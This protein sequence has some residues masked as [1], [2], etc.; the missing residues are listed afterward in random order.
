[1]KIYKNSDG[2]IVF[3]GEGNTTII[4]TNDVVHIDKSV[5]K[6]DLILYNF[7]IINDKGYKIPI[8]VKDDDVSYQYDDIINR[9]KLLDIR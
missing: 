6:E 2:Q 4:S 3:D 8:I 1:M 9:F 5:K 7:M